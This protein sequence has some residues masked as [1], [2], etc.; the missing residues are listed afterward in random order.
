MVHPN[1]SGVTPAVGLLVEVLSS[2]AELAAG[3]IRASLSPCS[4]S[5]QPRGLGSHRALYRGQQRPRHGSALA[6]LF[7]P[8]T[9]S[10]AQQGLDDYDL[11]HSISQETSTVFCFGLVLMFLNA[12]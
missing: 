11:L 9:D 8:M 5:G 12:V 6:L 7:I 2:S 10:T 1:L 3:G 4:I